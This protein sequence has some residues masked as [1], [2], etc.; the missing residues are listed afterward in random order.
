MQRVTDAVLQESLYS[1]VVGPGLRVFVLPRPG[2]R[3]A[4]ATFCTRYGSIDSMFVP[5]GQSEAVR[6]PDGIAHFL[7]HKLFEHATYNASDEFAKLGARDNAGTHWLWTTFYFSSTSRFEDCLELLLNYVQDP[8]FT[9]ESV[10]KEQGIIEQEVRMYQEDPGYRVIMELLQGLY[11][12]HPIRADIAGTVDSIKEITKD[13]LYECYRTFYHPSNM[14]VF[15]VGDLDPAKVVEQVR[16][17]I[18]GRGYAPQG[19]V[20]RVAPAEPAAVRDRRRV[21]ELVVAQ[22]ILRIGFKDRDVGYD[23]QRLLAKEL[24]T[25]VILEALLGRGSALY[26]ELYESGLIDARFTYGY[27]AASG[28]GFGY[29]GSPTRDPDALEKRILE[30]L[31][32]ARQKGLSEADFERAKKKQLGALLGYVDDQHTMAMLFNDLLLKGIDF[33]DMIPVGQRLTLDEAN[34]RLKDFFDPEY[35]TVALVVP[36]Q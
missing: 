21:A 8:W 12:N 27:D 25:L 24:L 10:A 6:V 16:R 5:P 19:E 18:E 22:P 2:F 33:F 34:A 30:G 29:V 36:K 13:L 28:Y 31:A 14:V 4:T 7:E 9:P 3:Q 26:T 32:A 11:Q 35:H 1:D 15:A 17:N 20:R 23:G